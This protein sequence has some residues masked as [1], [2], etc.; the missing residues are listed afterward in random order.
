MQSLATLN[1][2]INHGCLH[3]ATVF[4]LQGE[5]IVSHSPP[6]KGPLRLRGVASPS[7]RF[8]GFNAAYVTRYSP[9]KRSWNRRV[10]Q[11]ATSWL[12]GL[13]NR[14]DDGTKGG[15]KERK[16]GGVFARG[17]RAREDSA[18]SFGHLPTRLAFYMPDDAPTKHH[19]VK[20]PDRTRLAFSRIRTYRRFFEESIQ[21]LDRPTLN[22]KDPEALA[23]R[24]YSDFVIR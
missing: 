7:P 5:T 6:F 19:G 11:P 24:F 13:V 8:P 22:T 10:G 12:I 20:Q 3:G 1:L 4:L 23:R 2:Q 18:K 14:F 16:R 21:P 15:K 9:I 17:R